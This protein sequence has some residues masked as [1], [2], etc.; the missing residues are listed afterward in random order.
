MKNTKT[1]TTVEELIKILNK[2]DKKTRVCGGYFN[3]FGGMTHSDL[4][5]KESHL[6]TD[7]DTDVS[8]LLWLG[9]KE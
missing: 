4:I 2:Y 8:S 9:C 3:V 1:V 5:I 6:M 7:R